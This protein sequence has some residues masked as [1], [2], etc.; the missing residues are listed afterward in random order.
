M[1]GAERSDAKAGTER[2]RTPAPVPARGSRLWVHAVLFLCTCLTT[3]WV[4][5]VSANPEMPWLDLRQLAAH[6]RDGLPYAASI[7]GILFAHEM[8]HFVFA[9]WHGVRASLPYFIPIPL[10]PV[11]TLGAVIKMEGRISD[12]NALADIGASGPL[13][14]LLVAIPVLA[15]GLHLSPVRPIG[16]GILEGNSVLYLGL[17]LVLKGKILPGG[18]LDV[19][20]G[21]V[22]WAGWVGLLVT[23]INLMPIGQL[24]GGHIATA[25]FGD[26][27]NRVSHFLHRALPAMAVVAGSYHTW[28]L[29]GQSVVGSGAKGA[30]KAILLGAQA[31]FPWLLWSLIL[32]LIRRISG[33]V[34]HPPVG[35]A[36]LSAARRFLCVAML[37]V[38]VL[39][40]VPIP[41]RMTP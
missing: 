10:P 35:A 2:E 27:Y 28:E 29:W 39:I 13:A 41:I 32:L 8:G 26:R 21:P 9:R 17:K 7:M 25:Y 6:L 15:Y 33:G 3:T 24:D 20:L 31:G 23:M 11:G 22:A 38:F 12:R 34:Y 5:I 19:N 30:L 16:P 40:L 14:G 1:D 4:G 36:P 37:V 18:G